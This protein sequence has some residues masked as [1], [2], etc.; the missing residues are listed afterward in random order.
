MG[1]QRC[2][3]SRV[4]SGCSLTIETGWLTC[5]PIVGLKLVFF[6]DKL[7]VDVLD[8]GKIE[9]GLRHEERG[10]GRIDLER[11]CEQPC[12][13]PPVAKLTFK[14]SVENTTSQIAFCASQSTMYP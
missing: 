13:C 8:I 12:C 9:I 2:G 7:I 5:A 4:E 10:F 6:E 14:T 11:P 1:N 3:F